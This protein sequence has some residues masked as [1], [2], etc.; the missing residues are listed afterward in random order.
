MRIVCRHGYF[1]F[2]ELRVGQVSDFMSRY[3][4][5][6]VSKGNEFTFADLE[7][8]PKYSLKNKMLMGNIALENFEGEPWQVFEKNKL[9]YDFD[10][11][12][13]VPISSITQVVNIDESG[14]KFTSPGLIKPG[15]TTAGGQRVKD[16]STWFSRDTLTFLYSE[17]AY[18]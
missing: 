6:I 8:A 11:G 2:Q 17:V 7:S 1:T 18:V 12:L 9:V 15:S 3:G 5:S 4:L 10:L 14:N 16:Y 13:V